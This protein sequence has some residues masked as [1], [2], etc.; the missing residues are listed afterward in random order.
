MNTNTAKSLNEVITVKLYGCKKSITAP[1]WIITELGNSEATTA[2][3][4]AASFLFTLMNDAD[5]LKGYIMRTLVDSEEKNRLKK[6]INHIG[7]LADKVEKAKE[8][9]GFEKAFTIRLYDMASNLSLIA[10]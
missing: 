7:K 3:R 1:R 2:E 10:A 8:F 9:Y 5:T 6:M 4:D